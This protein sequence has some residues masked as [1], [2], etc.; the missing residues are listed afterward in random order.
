ML[1][2]GWPV[3]RDE[4]TSKLPRLISI[5]INTRKYEY[6]RLPP[7]AGAW[8]RAASN[9]ALALLSITGTVPS[10]DEPAIVGYQSK[11][12]ITGLGGVLLSQR[13]KFNCA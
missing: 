7:P 11:E 1:A 2:S 8:N 4:H 12:A 10:I 6:V 9:A 3:A 13:E 5:I